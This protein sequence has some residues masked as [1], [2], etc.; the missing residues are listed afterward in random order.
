[1][2]APSARIRNSIARARVR[3]LPVL[4]AFGLPVLAS[5]GTADAATVPQGFI[6]S[7]YISGVSNATGMEF[8]PD[9]RLFISEQAG[10]LRV[11]KNGAL[12]PSPAVTLT[13]NSEGERGL[14]GVTFDPNFATNHYMYVF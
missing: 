14:L 12:L 1:M 13:V 7:Q 5:S 11:V 8:A 3:I 10:R 9:G 4:V 2:N 6:S